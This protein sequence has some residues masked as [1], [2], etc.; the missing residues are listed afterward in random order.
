MTA[1]VAVVGV[2]GTLMLS[3]TERTRETG[4]L[5][6]VGLSRRGVRAMVAWEAALSGAGAAVIG[7]AVGS[8]YGALG[9]GVLGIVEGPPTLPFPSLAVL[10]VGVVVV[11]A[12]AATVP[13]IRA[14]RV[15]P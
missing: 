7:A 10:V 13:A 11:A 5:R 3:V 8:A 15:P 9:A 4:L 6:A 1:L 12:L 2:G 14:G